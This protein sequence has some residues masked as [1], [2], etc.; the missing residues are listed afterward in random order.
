L[1]VVFFI[2]LA[3]RRVHLAGITK[4]PDGRWVNQHFGLWPRFSIVD[5]TGSRSGSSVPK[6][7]SK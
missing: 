5:A 7:S 2:E 3:T 1:Y 4:H 6:P